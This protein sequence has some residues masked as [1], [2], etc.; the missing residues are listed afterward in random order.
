M[1]DD[2]IEVLRRLS[3]TIRRHD[4][5][6]T[7]NLSH[8]KKVEYHKHV[9]WTKKAPIADVLALVPIGPVYVYEWTA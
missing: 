4:Y 1:N 6:A 9:A 5:M 2:T 3:R 8:R 7:R